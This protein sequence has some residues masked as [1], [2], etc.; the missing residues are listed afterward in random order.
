VQIYDESTGL[1]NNKVDMNNFMD[2]F[3]SVLY[4][5]YW[6]DIPWKASFI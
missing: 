3:Y 5:D 2:N 6:Y 4:A 1:W